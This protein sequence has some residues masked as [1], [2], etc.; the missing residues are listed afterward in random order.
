M[1]RTGL[2][3]AMLLP[4]LALAGGV[5]V[6]L[7]CRRRSPRAVGF[8]VPVVAV[9]AVAAAYYP[10]RVFGLWTVP[11]DVDVWRSRL[12]PL[13]VALGWVLLPVAAMTDRRPGGRP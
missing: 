12:I 7:R 8:A 13:V 6:L 3:V 2:A 1:T 5:V 4:W 10:V 9:L 11:P